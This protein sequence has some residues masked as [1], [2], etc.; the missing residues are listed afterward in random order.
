MGATPEATR[1][2]AERFRGSAAPGH[3]RE[4][5]GLMMSSI[6]VG[7][8]LGETDAETDDRYR[9]AIIRAVELGANVIDTAINYRFQR[10]ERVIGQAIHDL[11]LGGKARRDELIIATKAGYLPFDGAYPTN[12]REYLLENFIAPG[13]IG[14]RDIVAGNHCMTPRYLEH[15]IDQSLKNLGA[16]TLDIFYVHNPEH[17]L[18][19]TDRDEFYKR[20][21]VAFGFLEG[22]V[23]SG[24]IRMY[25]TA[26]WNAYRVPPTSAE[27]MSIEDVLQCARDVAGDEH[28]FKVIQLPYNLA[29]PEAYTSA[30]QKL[31]SRLTSII[32]ACQDLNVSV[33]T[34]ASIFQSRLARNLPGFVVEHLSGLN[35]DAQRAIQFV[36]STP[37]VTTALVGM[38]HLRHVEENL[39][40]IAIDPSPDSVRRMLNAP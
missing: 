30:T 19:E 35:S 21:R 36:R 40:I 25:G 15:Q 5:H 39:G 3:F 1:R 12:P 2:Y 6:G 28:H 18:A 13:I 4:Q 7:T 37:G 16:H 9:R 11:E 38:S 24:K 29:M 23:R 8:Y 14:P 33:M 17:Q 34:S 31:R 27:Y 26:T 10:S 20:L 22:V 32:E